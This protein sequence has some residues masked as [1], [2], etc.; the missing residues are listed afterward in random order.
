MKNI[1]KRTKVFIGTLVII[2]T[3][4]IG[5]VLGS[6]V[7]LVF[8]GTSTIDDAKKLIQELTQNRNTI[9]DEYNK[10]DKVATDEIKSLEGDINS[11]EVTIQT[12]TQEKET[13]TEK[14]T[15]LENS[16]NNTQEIEQLKKELGDKDKEIQKWKD[17]RDRAYKE[18]WE[19]EQEKNNEI[20]NIKSE[21]DKINSEND[22]LKDELTKANNKCNELQTV[23]DN[24]DSKL[25]EF[26]ESKLIKKEN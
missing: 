16:N 18:K 23:I 10:L 17:D 4:F 2:S 22:K 6:E 3:F 12:L 21:K 13:L 26:E 15:I 1:K 25:K 8:K 24:T 7:L 19:L 5:S 20:S 14:I 9:I 11:K